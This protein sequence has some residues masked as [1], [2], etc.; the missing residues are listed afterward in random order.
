MIEI[1]IKG[2][3]GQFIKGFLRRIVEDKGVIA[4]ADD[5]STEELI[6]LSELRLPPTENS[7]QI[8]V[9]D[10][11]VSNGGLNALESDRFPNGSLAAH[12]PVEAL[13][14]VTAQENSQ[15]NSFTEALANLQISQ[16]IQ[17]PVVSSRLANPLTCLNCPSWWPCV[18]TK[19]R[20]AH[21]VVQLRPVL[22]AA[23][24]SAP[25]PPKE[26]T[27]LAASLSAMTE[28]CER[29]MLRPAT[30]PDAPSLSPE[31]LFTASDVSV[32]EG[33]LRYCGEPASL[34][35]EKDHLV[36]ISP[37][38][39][40]IRLVGLL[41]EM[42]LRMLRQKCVIIRY[43]NQTKKNQEG[44]GNDKDGGS[45]IGGQDGNSWNMGDD[46]HF[47]ESFSVPSLLMGLA[48]GAQGANIRNA[49]SIDGVLRIDVREAKRQ[50]NDVSSSVDASAESSKLG[51][52][53]FL[54]IFECPHANFIV[55]AQTA[56]AAKAARSM[57]E[58]CQV[59]ILIP[60]R[61]IGRIVGNK[62]TNIM[63]ISEKAELRHIHLES[64]LEEYGKPIEV[65]EPTSDGRLP[66]YIKIE[67]LHPE[68]A[69]SED[70]NKYSGFFLVG[71]REAV[72]RGRV[73][74]AF[75]LECI[76]DLEKLEGEKM[77][78][79]R[80]HPFPHRQD[81]GGAPPRGPRGPPRGVAAGDPYHDEV[82]RAGNQRMNRGG[83]ARNA[84]RPPRSGGDVSDDRLGSASPHQQDGQ[85][86]GADDAVAG[87]STGRHRGGAAPAQG[88]NGAQRANGT[89]R[90]RNRTKP[91]HQAGGL[92]GNP[93]A[94]NNALEGNSMANGN[95]VNGSKRENRGKDTSAPR[96]NGKR[97]PSANNTATEVS[98]A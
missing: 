58:Y 51:T 64:D 75:Q 60:K 85:A 34:Y 31:A 54:S 57:L 25:P 98:A 11:F 84:N 71:T 42:H 48:I 2:H 55:V 80:D 26:F 65:G 22:P 61:L 95:E 53:Y 30:S 83:G 24:E 70:A 41:E 52:P 13:L 43:I 62:S 72:E 15:E 32:H 36:V 67:D 12:L 5:P 21:A 69:N 10:N 73:L 47:I 23:D 19:V 76:Y 90:Q 92:P 1:E 4:Y 20:D 14:P 16:S 37:S 86:T 89:N 79:L 38:S 82:Q 17:Q 3:Y 97:Q 56:E 46:G 39:E 88:G 44:P 66:S 18:V 45:T 87:P 91:G 29:K 93:P 28:I 81:I 96:Q 49:R 74:I 8:F 78:L 50:R 77:D 9:V 94:E 33:I 63:S 7:D 35:V 27:D 68:L 59:C 6:P 40:V